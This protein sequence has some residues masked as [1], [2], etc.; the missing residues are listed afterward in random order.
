MVSALR[1]AA[2]FLLIGRAYEHIRWIGPYRDF[3][4]NPIG[5]GKWYANFI[6]RDLVEIYKD[7]FYEQLVSS[8][9]TGIGIVFLGAACVI[10][11]YEKLIGWSWIIYVATGFLLTTYLGYF[12]IKHFQ[13]WGMLL[14]HAAQLMMPLLFLWYMKNNQARFLAVATWSVALTFYCHGLF[15]IGF[16]PQPGKFVDMFIASTGWTEDFVRLLLLVVGWLDI[17]MAVIII[18]PFLP[19]T[20]DLIHVRIFRSVFLISILYGVIWGGITTLAR[21]Y[22]T[23]TKG[24]FWHWADQYWMEF[25]VRLPHFVLPLVIFLIIKNGKKMKLEPNKILS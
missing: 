25:L 17:I 15:A 2:V 11:F 7:P 12:M 13:M 19:G 10:L 4:Y 18:V 22:A 21:L 3:F 5:F 24:M 8:I 9:S 20:S 16:Y 23:Y 14:E 6:G 1:Y